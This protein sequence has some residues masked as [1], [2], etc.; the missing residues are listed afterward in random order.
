MD[1]I[2]IDAGTLNASKNSRIV[3]G[4]LVP[5]GEECRSDIGRFSFEPGVIKVPTDL[6]GMSLNIE[7]EREKIVGAPASIRETAKGIVASF[8]IA[9]TKAGDAALAAIRSGK[10][11]RLSA[12]ISDVMIRD[13]KGVAG[14]LFAAAVCEKPAFPSATLLAA[15]P[16]TEDEGEDDSTETHEVSEYTDENGVTWRRV[17]DTETE[18]DGDTTTTTTTIVEEITEPDDDTEETDPIEEEP[19]TA[20]TTL[21]AKAATKPRPAP[22]RTEQRPAFDLGTVYASIAAGR[23]GD[24]Q[25]LTFLGALTD[26]KTN[27]PLGKVGANGTL[28]ENW[29]GQI[30]DGREYGR[31]FLP[32]GTVGTEITA[33]G[34][35]GYKAHRGTAA[36]PIEHHDGEW[37]G[38]LSAIKSGTGY[39]EELKSKL[40]KF[41]IAEAI[42]REFID[43]PG[44]GEIVEA[45]M[46]LLMEDYAYWSDMKALQTW[47]TAAGAPV[48]PRAVPA[49]Y[50]DTPALGQLIQG[51]LAV[52][53]T[54]DTPTF[55]IVNQTAYEQLLY[56]PKDLVP[57]YVTFD[58][59]TD[60][61]GSADAGK[62]QVVVADDA[63]F[64]DAAGAPL[65][66]ADTPATLVGAGSA[67]DFDE[68]GSTPLTVD[69]LEIARGGIDRAIH[70]YL[71]VF[72]KR[73]ASVSLIGTAPAAG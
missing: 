36:T 46:K 39:T 68:L 57:E 45:F 64:V 41:A 70:G 28:P 67:V 54:R 44:G 49:R 32:L 12:E 58:F 40:H 72:V 17:V 23:R 63:Q 43:L 37:A 38:D 48:T 66:A 56:T 3:T 69:A 24:Q 2:T 65:V 59:R 30:W 51:V 18:T 20:S 6:T 42:A 35:R 21:A 22:V 15:A 50:A 10:R 53:R 16:D 73:A 55:A 8:A 27:G 33:T 4:L 29:V 62:V 5:Y 13:G 1:H 71:Q 26:I 19:M 60:L 47:L 31:K 25:A 61:T 14:N 7:H 52:E 34:K 9:K 11:K